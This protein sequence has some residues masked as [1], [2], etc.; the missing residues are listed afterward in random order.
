MCSGKISTVSGFLVL[1]DIGTNEGFYIPLY[2]RHSIKSFNNV[3]VG[4]VVELKPDACGVSLCPFFRAS[5][6][7][8]S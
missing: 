4:V 7:A 2:A 1:F 5:V 8:T 3:C 6:S